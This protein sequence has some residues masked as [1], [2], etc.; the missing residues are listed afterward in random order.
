M[1]NR[2]AEESSPY[3]LQHAE[4]PVDWYPWGDEAF[5]LARSRNR[6]IFLSVGYSACHWCHVMAHESFEDEE[7]AAFLNTHFVAVK[8]DREERPDVDS[9]YM[10]AVQ[11]IAGR[12]GWPMSVFMTPAGEPFFGGT[13]WPATSRFGM[14]SFRDVLEQIA[15]LWTGQHGT[16]QEAAQRLTATLRN[17]DEQRQRPTSPADERTLISAERGLIRGFDPAHGGWGE[18]PKFPQPSVIE[19][20]MRRYQATGEQESLTMIDRTLEAMAAGGIHDQVGGGFHRYATD[21]I[22]LVPHFEKMLYDNAQLARVYLHAWQLTGN[23]D[24]KRVCEDTLDYLLREMTDPEG[25]FYAAQDADTGGVEGSYYVWTPE[26][27]LAA[28]ADAGA[29]DPEADGALFSAAYGVTTDGNF[30]GSTI[31]HATLSRE[32]LAA[33]FDESEDSIDRRLCDIRVAL[34]EARGKRPRPHTDDKVIAAWNGLALGA[35]AEA[36]R[37]LGRTDYGAAATANAEFLLSQMYDDPGRLWRTWS[38]GTAKIDAFLEDYACVADGLIELYQTTF[39]TR[40]L[41][42][43]HELAETIVHGLVDPSGGFFDTGHDHEALILRPRDISDGATPSGSA[44]AAYVLARLAEYFADASYARLAHDA[45]QEVGSLMER[46]PL[47]FSNWLGVLDFM[48]APPMELALVGTC[49][50]AMLDVVRRRY[51]PNLVVACSSGAA[52][53]DGVPL[54]KGRTTVG[55]H[56]TAYLCQQSSCIDPTTSADRLEVLLQGIG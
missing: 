41:H 47:G 35:F 24:H 52:G 39:D 23:E 6:P 11:S 25:G 55:G 8:V 49:P 50:G 26:Q 42:S 17:A 12:G 54:L 36:A 34:L 10:E 7:T 1:T 16:V 33:T 27:I 48:L 28:L 53:A 18:A 5:A 45:V 20:V 21:A 15:E 4:N 14:P 51:R 44:M 3:L 30:E 9:I 29:Q 2:L 43:A 56:T 31:L 46:A 32:A 40:W 22:W 37:V 38:A 13:Y 19:F